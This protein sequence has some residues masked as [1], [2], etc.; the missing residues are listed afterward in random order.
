MQE[1]STNKFD[2]E[3]IVLK[4]SNLKTQFFV[5]DGIVKAIEDVSFKLHKGEVLGIVGETGCG[6][7]VTAYSI[8][9]LIPDPPGRVVS[10]QIYLG[11]LNILRNLDKEAKINT[12]RKRAKIKRNRRAIKRN[13]LFFNQI[14]GK[15]ISMIFQEPM[16]ALNPVYTIEDQIIETL[17]LHRRSHILEV[18]QGA[19]KSIDKLVKFRKMMEEDQDINPEK[20][21]DLREYKPDI[22]NEFQGALKD[23]MI[24]LADSNKGVSSFLR[25]L[26]FL[27]EEGNVYGKKSN[28]YDKILNY[29]KEMDSLR[30][31]L[32]RET[33]ES[34]VSIMEKKLTR[35]SKKINLIKLSKQLK[36]NKK[37]P[38]IIESRREALGLLEMVNIADAVGILKRYPHELSGGMLQRVVISIALANEPEILIA[39]EPTTALDVTVQAQILELMRQLQKNRGTSIILI[40]HDLGVIAEMCDRVAVMYAGNIVEVGS[41]NEVF[42]NPKHP[43][44]IGLLSS[45]PRIDNPDKKLKSIPGTVPNLLNPPTGCRFNPRCPLAFDKCRID[46]PSHIEVSPNHVVACHLFTGTEVNDY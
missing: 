29:D 43:Y 18:A 42:H 28:K 30:E 7:S 17:V 9:K 39:D 23:E 16:A 12:N 31:Q 38:I 14:R 20:V 36:R 26:D 3:E 6:K 25:H 2:K 24:E 4:V 11:N 40:T 37:D 34:K 8:T 21:A 44:T 15:Y 10:G 13:E 5:Y 46:V 32:L 45:I 41:V 19:Y 33:D 27:I 35:Y 1:I 22:E